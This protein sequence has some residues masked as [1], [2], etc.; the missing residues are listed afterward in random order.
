[1]ST[2][3]TAG[4]M[5][6]R[7]VPD[8]KRTADLVQEISA[9]SREQ[10]QG[11]DQVNKAIQQMSQVVQ[12]NAAAAEELASTSE[13]LSAQAEELQKA[14]DYFQ[15]N[16]PAGQATRRSAKVLRQPRAV[17]PAKPKKPLP[18]AGGKKSLVLEMGADDEDEEFERM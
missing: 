10:S 5:L 4:E 13:E 16:A 17:A 6:S 11:A 3:I 12:M 18:A 2:A 8:I 15:T 1:V 14:L 9:A 7:L